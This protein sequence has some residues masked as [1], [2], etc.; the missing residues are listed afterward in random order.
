MNSQYHAAVALTHG[1]KPPTKWTPE[2]VWTLWR[3]ENYLAS[4]GNR[5]ATVQAVAYPYTD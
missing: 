4:A 2:S 5:T 1:E 3:K